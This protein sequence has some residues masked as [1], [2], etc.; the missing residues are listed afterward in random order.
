[1]EWQAIITLL[2]I[3]GAIILFVSEWISVDLV[4][5]LIM[6]T[7]VITGVVTPRESVEGFSN[8]ATITVA[9]MF[10]LSEALLRTGALNSWPTDCLPSSE[11]DTWQAWH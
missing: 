5:L 8:N 10:V 6:V 2:V 9:F 4:A 11:S 1:M 3:L 7:L